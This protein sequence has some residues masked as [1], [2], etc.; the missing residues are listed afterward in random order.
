MTSDEEF[1][2][3]LT[4]IETMSPEQLNGLIEFTNRT[5]KHR[6]AM[7]SAK[8]KVLFKKG[9]RV[10]LQGLKPQYLN[11]CGGVINSML[12]SKIEVK[13]DRPVGKFRTGIVRVPASALIKV[14]VEMS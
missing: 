14:E 13:L 5:I 9:D 2:K 4:N 1:K 12:T 6:R 11:G 7:A 8:A 10:M 3:T